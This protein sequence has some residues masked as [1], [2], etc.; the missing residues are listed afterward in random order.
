MHAS[1]RTGVQRVQTLRSTSLLE[2]GLEDAV[3][4]GEDPCAVSAGMPRP[5]PNPSPLL[6]A[7][8][9]LSTQLCLASKLCIPITSTLPRSFSS[10]LVPSFRSATPVSSLLIFAVQPQS[11]R[12]LNACN[13]R[14]SLIHPSA[15]SRPQPPKLRHCCGSLC[16]VDLPLPHS[17]SPLVPLEHLCCRQ[18]AA[19]PLHTN[20]GSR[21][22]LFSRCHP[23]VNNVRHGAHSATLPR[24][25]L[26]E[27]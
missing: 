1:M 7:S 9:K 3:S 14:S 6:S 25:Q 12:T 5:G 13:Y 21:I 22:P 8:A 15:Q 27:R 2:A 11:C 18:S 26:Q 20:H 10:L 4:F 19:L 16:P 17:A 23:R 24:I